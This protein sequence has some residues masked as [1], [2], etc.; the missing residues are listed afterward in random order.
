[1]TNPTAFGMN[2]NNLMVG[3]EA[4]PEAILPL[5]TLFDKM[6]DMFDNQNRTIANTLANNTHN[7]GPVTLIMEM[8]GEKVA[9][10]TVK[11]M[12]DLARIGALDMTWL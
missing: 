5:D 3:G 1:M 10:G 8:D 12:Q 6:N 2:G 7:T 11:N 9:K 4:G